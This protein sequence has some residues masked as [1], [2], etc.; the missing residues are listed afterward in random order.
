MV[1]RTGRRTATAIGL[2]LLVSVMASA[3]VLAECFP[4][5]DEGT[6][7]VRPYVFTA[8]VR[9]VTTQL[10]QQSVDAGEEPGLLW[11]ATL[12]LTRVYSGPV[13]NVLILHG[14]TYDSGDGGGCTYFLGARL[15]RGDALL[16][17]LDEQ[18]PLATNWGL[19][20][21]LLLWHRVGEGWRFYARALQ[22]G[23][24]P[25]AYPKLARDA[26][27]TSEVLAAIDRL[28]LPDTATQSLEPARSSVD[29]VR[30]AGS[31]FASAL[32]AVALDSSR[33]RRR[34]GQA[35]R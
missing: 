4:R 23:S 18:I 8:T 25:H 28:A 1:H 20:G 13:P 29:D 16:I 15:H 12:D 7:I 3:T 26:R 21:N 33:H 31:I 24:E 14:L 5:P 10:D 30:L 32:L 27:T 9:T 19:F 2:G 22:E 6:P 17:A 11:T 35:R 34:F